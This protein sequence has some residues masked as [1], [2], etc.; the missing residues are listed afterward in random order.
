MYTCTMYLHV[1]TYTCT[2]SAIHCIYCLVGRWLLC[3][4]KNNLATYWAYK[5]DTS[6]LGYYVRIL[7]SITSTQEMKKLEQ[8]FLDGMYCIFHNLPLDM[9]KSEPEHSSDQHTS[10]CELE[11]PSRGPES[12]SEPSSCQPPLPR[13]KG[14]QLVRQVYSVYV[15]Y[16]YMYIYTYKNV[17]TSIFTSHEF[18]TYTH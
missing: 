1:A 11:P 5:H 12:S 10:S 16:M 15:Q 14:R 4:R 13:W 3:L 8:K 17:C 2:S 18:F 7:S 9:G 6:S